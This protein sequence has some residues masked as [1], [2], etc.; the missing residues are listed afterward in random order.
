MRNNT[1]NPARRIVDE[2]VKQVRRDRVKS[3]VEAANTAI[4]FSSTSKGTDGGD[5]FTIHPM[6][7][8]LD[9]WDD[10]GAVWL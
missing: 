9:K 10:E 8:D 5:I 4:P 3:P 1:K 7:W 6:F 2:A